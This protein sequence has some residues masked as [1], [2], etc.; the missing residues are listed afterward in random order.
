MIGNEI[1][2]FFEI[3]HSHRHWREREGFLSSRFPLPRRF[4]FKSVIPI[5]ERVN[6]DNHFGKN[7]DSKIRSNERKISA[8]FNRVAE[9]LCSYYGFGALLYVMDSSSSTVTPRSRASFPRGLAG[10]QF[11][12][13]AFQEDINFVSSNTNFSTRLIRKFIISS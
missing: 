6:F 9:N 4:I 7:N 11:S 12:R 3:A 13:P 1:T 8:D 5:L 2:C 10:W